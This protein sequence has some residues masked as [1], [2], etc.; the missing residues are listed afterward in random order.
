MKQ[1]AFP[2][3]HTNRLPVTEHASV[4]R[5]RSVADLVPVLR[6][7]RD[8]RFHCGLTRLLERLDASRG[9]QEIHGHVATATERGLEFL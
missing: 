2:L 9:R 5:E 1:D 7:L 3:L 8:R 4:D 6:A